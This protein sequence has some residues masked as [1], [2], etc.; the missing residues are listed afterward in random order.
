MFLLGPCS[1]IVPKEHV[2][3][4]VVPEKSPV[5]PYFGPNWAFIPVDDNR[6]LDEMKR[7]GRAVAM[8]ALKSLERASPAELQ[9]AALHAYTLDIPL[10]PALPG[11]IEDVESA[12]KFLVPEYESF[13]RSGMPL[14]HMRLLANRLNWLEWAGKKSL[15]L[16][17]DDDRQAGKKEMPVSILQLNDI[18]LVFMHSEI[19]METDEAFACNSSRHETADGEV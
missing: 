9:S 8:A 11:S 1:N 2:A 3:Y 7:I 16:F 19:A 5:A 6:L 12:I 15:G 13:L 18:N 4:N 17:T 14:I 10:D